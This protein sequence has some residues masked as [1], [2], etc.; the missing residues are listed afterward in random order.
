MLDGCYAQ[1]VGDVFEYG[2][3]KRE[4][5]F[6]GMLPFSG[7]MEYIAGPSRYEK[8]GEASDMETALIA[9]KALPNT[10]YQG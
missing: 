10:T 7:W 6:T 5:H 8:I 4:W 2:L 3:I 9:M 1:K